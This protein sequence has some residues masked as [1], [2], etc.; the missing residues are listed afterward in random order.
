LSK[1]TEF[2]GD[3]IALRERK[4]REVDLHFGRRAPDKPYDEAMS[5]VRALVLSELQRA[6]KDGIPYVL[7]TH[8]ASTS[9]GWQKTTARS[10][11]RGLMRDPASTPYIVRRDCIQHETAFLARIRGP[12]RLNTG[13]A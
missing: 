13:K 6:Q 1:F 7:F 2:R 10:I 9:L 12:R 4:P 11:V 8:G 5:D 3:W